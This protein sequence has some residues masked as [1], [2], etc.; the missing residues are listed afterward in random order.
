[1]N[2]KPK[3]LLID[4]DHALIHMYTLKFSLDGACELITADTQERGLEVAQQVHPDLILLDLIMP[5]RGG[6][7]DSLDKETGFQLL[8]ALKAESLTKDIPVVVLTN[9][10]EQNHENVER[11]KAL[12]ALDYWVK[13]LFAPAEVLAKVKAILTLK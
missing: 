3:I 6:L 9:L 10:D 5:K 8:E 2:H 11:A 7:M 12:G 4:D 1:M 13:A